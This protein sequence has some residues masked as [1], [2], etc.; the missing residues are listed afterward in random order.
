MAKYPNIPSKVKG[1]LYFVIPPD[2]RP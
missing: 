2:N 1:G